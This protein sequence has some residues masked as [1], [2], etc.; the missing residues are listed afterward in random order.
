MLILWLDI[1][2]A[3]AVAAAARHYITT[4][5]GWLIWAGFFLI[6][7]NRFPCFHGFRGGKGVASYLGFTALIVPWAAL[8]AAIVWVLVYGVMRVPFIA[9]FFM[10]AV[11]SI[12]HSLSFQWAPAATA[13]AAA[14]FTLIIF[15]HR[16]NMRQYRK[17]RRRSRARAINKE[18]QNEFYGLMCF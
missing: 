1:G 15:N 8:F 13:A 3:V 2:R 12:G 11:L 18:L 10:V 4:D 7:G 14:T 5:G 9:S 6:L 17:D 16:I